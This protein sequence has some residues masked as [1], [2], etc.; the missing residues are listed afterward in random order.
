MRHRKA[1]YL[2]RKPVSP[3]LGTGDRG[4]CRGAGGRK[5]LSSRGD[6]MSQG[7][8]L[9]WARSRKSKSPGG[10]GARGGRPGQENGGE[11]A[12]GKLE[13]QT[14]FCSQGRRNHQRFVKQGSGKMGRE[15]RQSRQK[16]DWDRGRRN[17]C[18]L[19]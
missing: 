13:H 2:Q 10:A 18:R 9:G 7:S 17:S 11:M 14:R 19:L 16:Q 8:W 6:P 3:K 12:E 15:S 5:V 1:S 4:D